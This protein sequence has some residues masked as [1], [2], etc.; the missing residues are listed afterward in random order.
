MKDPN[1]NIISRT[2]GPI[3]RLPTE[4]SCGESVIDDTFHPFLAAQS[5]R[6]TEPCVSKPSRTG[7][8]HGL[9]GQ[10]SRCSSLDFSVSRHALL[11]I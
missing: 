11:D 9:F 1:T 8:P 10:L 2:P 5:L 7:A 3:G 4:V 6:S